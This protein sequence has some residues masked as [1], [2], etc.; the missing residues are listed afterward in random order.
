MNNQDSWRLLIIGL[1]HC[2]WRSL[3]VCISVQSRMYSYLA[4]Y[5]P[6]ID[7]SSTTT[8]PRIKLILNLI[9]SENQFNISINWSNTKYQD[10]GW[11][12]PSLPVSN[13]SLVTTPQNT[14][15]KNI[16]GWEEHFISHQSPT[17]NLHLQFYSKKFYA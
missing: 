15:S 10:F 8:L 11:N 9:I 3:S 6:G 4:N 1:D 14:R 17:I 2:L 7:S 12:R 16:L 5:F 13:I